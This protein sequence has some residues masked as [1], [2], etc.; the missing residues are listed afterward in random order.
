MQIQKANTVQNT[1]NNVQAAGER[2]RTS[3]KAGQAIR[4]ARRTEETTIRKTASARETRT[5][6]TREVRQTR[7]EIA[8]QTKVEQNT[9]TAVNQ[10][11]EIERRN[12]RG[13]N[14]LNVVA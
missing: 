8:R 12:P 5:E 3:N 2:A 10:N 13:G 9:R 11:Q 14:L 6:R 1:V 7:V 4:N